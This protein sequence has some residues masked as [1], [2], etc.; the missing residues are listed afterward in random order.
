MFSIEDVGVE[1]TQN[2][3]DFGLEVFRLEDDKA[4]MVIVD[5][6][7]YQVQGAE[8]N[9]NAF[10]QQAETLQEQL[11]N[12]RNSQFDSFEGSE[13]TLS[14]IPT[15]TSVVASPMY[16]PDPGYFEIWFKEDE[17]DSVVDSFKEIRG[18]ENKIIES[19][20]SPGT[21]AGK[22]T[23][24]SVEALGDY[25]RAFGDA[26]GYPE[27]CIEE[28]VDR[29]QDQILKGLDFIENNDMSGI[30][31]ETARDEMDLQLAPETQA[32]V[33]DYNEFT[34]HA[35][36][37]AVEADEVADLMEDPPRTFFARYGND[38]YPVDGE[39]IC[40]QAISNG[41]DI[42]DSLETDLG[43]EMYKLQLTRNLAY[44]MISDYDMGNQVTQETDFFDDVGPQTEE[45]ADA[46]RDNRLTEFFVTEYYL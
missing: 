7:P 36:K 6:F 27:C 44:H 32:S 46:Y 25:H 33:N 13:L 18:A 37:A 3:E 42:H 17:Y 8:M 1:A 9:L 30:N 12:R 21:G 14:L 19:T 34:W 28:F 39:Q 15:L 26:L 10:N 2:G 16:Q 35:L 29:K 43:Q 45:L 24:E 20:Q 11:E 38:F 41:R 23:E 4:E 40:R 5:S 22:H 31:P